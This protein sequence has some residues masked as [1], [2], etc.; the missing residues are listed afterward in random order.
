MFPEE[1][2]ALNPSQRA[3]LL[4]AA[5]RYLWWQQPEEALACPRRILA[6]V[7]N[8]GVWEDW[9]RMTALFTPEELAEVL[10]HAEMG[11]FSPRS[12]SFWHCRFSGETPPLPR[13]IVP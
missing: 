4:E 11:Q 10:A 3:F 6:Q 7:M 1:G 9:C 2:G 8:L 12:W 13:R 5:E